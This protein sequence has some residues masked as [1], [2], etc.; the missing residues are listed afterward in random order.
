VELSFRIVFV[1]PKIER[2]RLPAI[3]KWHNVDNY[4]TEMKIPSFKEINKWF[5]LMLFPIVGLIIFIKPQRPK[6]ESQNDLILM[7]KEE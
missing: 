7:L 4:K 6:V 1:K 2:L 5:V 3:S